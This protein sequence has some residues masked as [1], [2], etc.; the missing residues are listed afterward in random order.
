MKFTS[1]ID[2]FIY[3]EGL[4]EAAEEDAL[5]IVKIIEKVSAEV[6]SLAVSAAGLSW[7]ERFG[8]YADE[9]DS[10]AELAG[11][12]TLKLRGGNLLY[13]ISQQMDFGL[14]CSSGLIQTDGGMV[15]TRCLDWDIPGLGAL[16]RIYETKDSVI[17]GFAGFH[18]AAS[19]M[20]NG[21]FSLSLNWAPP[22]PD[23]SLMRSA[24][25]SPPF[26]VRHI[27]EH[28]TSYAEAKEMLTRTELSCPALFTLCG[29]RKGQGCLVERTTDE[30][31]VIE[32]K[33]SPITQTNHFQYKG[34]VERN[35]TNTHEGDIFETEFS[36]HRARKL[37]K[38]LTK[39]DKALS[40]EAYR[41]PL[42]VGDVQSEIT[43]QQM[44]FLPATSEYKV[45]RK[46]GR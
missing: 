15:H 8:G 10:A 7:V 6:G 22:D 16:S 36:E 21:K 26:L 17:V 11:V 2:T 35:E 9:I 38:G 3:D 27:L 37:K 24:G 33:G 40:L 14:G 30:Y 1:K 18:G 44:V 45:W 29:S 43:Y 12:P 28:A 25:M 5:A 46:L 42:T 39:S 32:F 13:D 19:G 31:G 23:L 41:K 34:F 20:V 4:D